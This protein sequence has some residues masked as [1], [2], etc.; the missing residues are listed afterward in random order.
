MSI[1]TTTYFIFIHLIGDHFMA[2]ISSN[3]TP[4]GVT[5]SSS[6]STTTTGAPVNEN[7]AFIEEPV[8]F[9]G[10]GT[11]S[12]DSMDGTDSTDSTDSSDWMNSTGTE[13]TGDSSSGDDEM[14]FGLV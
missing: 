5:P 2:T 6:G 10:D 12:A 4:V 3:Y 8:D 9:F 14:G 7:Q 11:E 13:E 1:R